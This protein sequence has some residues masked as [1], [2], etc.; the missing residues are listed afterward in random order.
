MDFDLAA[1][2]RRST[3]DQGVPERIVDRDTL[4]AVAQM[5][6]LAS[7]SRSSQGQTQTRASASDRDSRGGL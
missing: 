6:R 5:V 7:E 2:V 1:Y 3:E 4:I